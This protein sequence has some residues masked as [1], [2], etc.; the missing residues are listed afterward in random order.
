MSPAEELTD[1]A[2]S[3]SRKL[4]DLVGGLMA[5]RHVEAEGGV[6]TVAEHCGGSGTR[7]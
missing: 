5:D 7:P 1:L 3:G 4:Q 6:Q 2:A